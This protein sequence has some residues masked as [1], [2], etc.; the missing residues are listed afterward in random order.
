MESHPGKPAGNCGEMFAE[1]SSY[2]DRELPED[3]CRQI[4]EHLAGCEPCIEF[5]RSLRQTID[6][7]HEHTPEEIPPPLSPEAREKLLAACKKAL[8]ARGAGKA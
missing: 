7:C 2:L 8:A 3:S 6:L 4:E 1:L 5:V